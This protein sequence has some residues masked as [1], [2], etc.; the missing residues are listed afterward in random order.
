MY[1]T[2]PELH[3]TSSGGGFLQ[4]AMAATRGAISIQYPPPAT[5]L[6]IDP[7]WASLFHL[8]LLFHD[9]FLFN[10]SFN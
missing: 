8:A 2:H 3:T 7:I 6:A 4:F 10:N 1:T 5:Q 9:F